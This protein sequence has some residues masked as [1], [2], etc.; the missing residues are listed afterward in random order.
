MTGNHLGRRGLLRLG[1]VSAAAVLLGTGAFVSSR[2]HKEPRFQTDPFS[3]GVAS[4]DPLPD[5]VVLW[6]RLAP[7]PLAPDGLG[8]MP[9]TPVRVRWQVATDERFRHVVRYGYVETS[10]ELAHSVHAEVHG[11]APGRGYFYRFAAGNAESPVGRTRTA[12]AVGDPVGRLRFA[13]ASCQAWQDGFYT[14]YRHMA[15]EDLDFVVHLGD[16]IY[17]NG[18]PSDGATRQVP[19]PGH[20]GWEAVTLERYRT[21][22][23]LYKSDPDLRAAHAAFPW[24]VTL[25]DHDVENGWAGD[26]PERNTLTPTRAEFLRRRAAAFRALYEHLPIRSTALPVGPE[27]RVFRRFTYG[28][29]AEFNLLDTRQHRSPLADPETRERFD[30]A[31]TLT[32]EAQERWLLDGLAA[33]R[34]RWNVIAQQIRVAQFY[35]GARAVPPQD[36]G[37]GFGMDSWDGYVASRD[38]IFGGIAARRVANPVVLTGDWHRNLVADIKADYADPDSATVATELVGT[39]I[40]SGGDGTDVDDLGRTRVAGNPHVKFY[41]V[42]RG[43][44]SCR[45][46][47]RLWTTN[48]TVV[49]WVRTP[50]APAAVRATFVVEDGRPGAAPG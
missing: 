38:R 6:T 44:V 40:S 8:G 13:F 3:L 41:N 11:L 33:S 37:T 23:A 28:D 34:A 18:I 45:L 27:M 29:L 35:H 25:D 9:P 43:Y 32:G 30:P 19:L 50:N 24:L 1:G 36:S 48:F 10:P 47:H 7:D 21:Q 12:P 5:G 14:A 15:A 2:P 46:D 22:Y 4:G 17:E 26:V 31:R 16:Y 20:L 39:S 42:Q 49:P